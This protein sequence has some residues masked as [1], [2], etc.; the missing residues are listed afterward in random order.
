MASPTNGQVAGGTGQDIF[1]SIIVGASPTSLFEAMALEHAGKTVLIVD[2]QD[3]LGGAWT[4]RDLPRIGTVECGTHYLIDLPGVYEFMDGIPGI[5]LR[6]V[7][8]PPQYVLPRPVL[9]RRTVDFRSRWAGKISPRIP[10]NRLSVSAF[11][12]LVSPYYRYARGMLGLDGRPR[13]PLQYIEG[14]TPALVEALGNL[15]S[16]Q[17][18]EV[19]LNSNIDEVR[20]SPSTGSVECRIGDRV[21]VSSELVVPGSAR[22]DSVFINQTPAE[23]PG[24]IVPSVQLH[25]LVRGASGQKFS[26]VQFSGSAYANLASD[27]TATCM[28][29]LADGDCRI[30]SAYVRNDVR[31]DDGTAEA[32]LG[33]L[34]TAGLLDSGASLAKAHWSRF[35]LPQRSRD[36]LD[37]I[38]MKAEGLFRTLYAHSFS[39]AISENA[40]RWRP[41]LRSSIERRTGHREPANAIRPSDAEYDRA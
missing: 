11:R 7:D 3:R 15:V 18:F 30:L 22:L 2:G 28:P 5:N 32:I 35:D 41:A 1:D 38:G 36:E 19:L 25:M 21:V 39:M 16:R 6:P 4:T 24:E 13:K 31:H 26:F 8:P 29:A 20:A 34:K 17:S 23:L 9:G 12:N 10:G 37:E 33:E 40:S 14:G 27:L